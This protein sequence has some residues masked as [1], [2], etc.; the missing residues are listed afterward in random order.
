M[1]PGIACYSA[2]RRFAAKH[3]S[4][5][6]SVALFLAAALLVGA[7][8]EDPSMK[9]NQQGL[10]YYTAGDYTRARAAFEEAVNISP[11]V[12]EYYFNRGVCEQT[13]GNWDQAI[14]N[15]EMAT[16]LS[17][18]IVAAFNNAAQCCIEKGD[19]QKAQE[20]L[21]TGTRVNPI[22]GEAFINVSKFFEARNDMASAKL[23]MAK[24]VAA[25]PESAKAHL[26]YA[27]I[28]LKTGDR[29]KGIEELR[30]SLDLNPLQPDVS[31]RLTDLAPSGAQLPPPK[32][33]TQ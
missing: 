31:S 14:L 5:A 15:Y 19:P 10:A 30:K 9:F 27:N 2:K 25:D 28:L 23:W 12:G 11:D 4:R 26:A 24:A 29:Q 32:P 18:R 33:Q 6:C 7:G 17:P 22:N 16:K 21:L 3:E 13:I 8:C 20:W 1:A